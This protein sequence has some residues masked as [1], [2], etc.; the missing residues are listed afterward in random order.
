MRGILDSRKEG[1]QATSS[2]GFVDPRR[3]ELTV[4]GEYIVYKYITALLNRWPKHASQSPSAPRCDSRVSIRMHI[5]LRG[6]ATRVRVYKDGTEDIQTLVR[7][8]K[9]N[10]GSPVKA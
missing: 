5:N 4:C 8:L 3:Q 10:S 7:R 2:V 1:I 9:I 6:M